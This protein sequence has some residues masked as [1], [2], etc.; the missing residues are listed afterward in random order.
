MPSLLRKINEN[1]LFQNVACCSCDWNFKD[2]WISSWFQHCKYIGLAFIGSKILSLKV[3]SKTIA[4]VGCFGVWWLRQFYYSH[5]Q[6]VSLPNH[7]FMGRLSPVSGYPVLMYIISPETDNCP[8]W[9]SGRER[10]TAENIWW[11]FS[12][13][14][15]CWTW[16]R[17]N[18]WLDLSVRRTPNSAT[19]AS[20]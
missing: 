10:L 8:S 15:C 12:T 17:S 2:Y 4:D 18:Q 19:E 11:S 6:P 14:E 13:K 16:C 20:L 9:D 1:K 7:T 3:P 5:V